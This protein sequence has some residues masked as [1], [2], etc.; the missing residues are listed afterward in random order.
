MSDLQYQV[1]FFRLRIY[2]INW[3]QF[4]ISKY[5]VNQVILMI[6]KNPRFLMALGTCCS[7]GSFLTFLTPGP[8]LN[9]PQPSALLVLLFKVPFLPYP[10][11]CAVWILSSTCILIFFFLVLFKH[12]QPL[13]LAHMYLPPNFELFD[14]MGS[15][16]TLNYFLRYP[17]QGFTIQGLWQPNIRD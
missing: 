10:V 13:L 9:K 15:I 14:N 16:L 1:P 4:K 6:K 2:F 11:P 5:D 17:A 3:I 12:T 7:W 8:S